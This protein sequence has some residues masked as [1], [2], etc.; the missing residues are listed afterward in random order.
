VPA[1][2]PLGT[3][4]ATSILLVCSVAVNIF[5]SH[6]LAG[7]TELRSRQV[8]NAMFDPNRAVPPLRL[9]TMDGIDVA[10]NIG[11]QQLP[12]ILYVFDPR[13]GWCERNADNVRELALQT[14]AR[15][16]VIGISYSRAGLV[17]YVAKH[18]FP[19]PVYAEPS[20]ATRQTYFLQGT[21]QTLVVSSSC[22]ILRSWRGAY[23]AQ[24]LREIEGYFKV[25]LPGLKS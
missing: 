12:T 25:H 13:C 3:L 1:K 4:S 19:F 6:R 21:P 18:R 9:L 11:K 22:R 24:L 23:E 14:R 10:I 8:R 15:Y 5:L 16:F 7:L 17:D 2:N 20:V